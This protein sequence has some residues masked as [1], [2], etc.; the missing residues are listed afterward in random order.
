MDTG[1]IELGRYGLWCGQF[2]GRDTEAA[3]VA[4]RE[5][6]ALGYGT[7]W[8][9]GGAGGEI[10]EIMGRLLDGTTTMVAA[11]GIVNVWA[12]TPAE[13]ATA[14]AALTAAHPGRFLCGLGISHSIM[15]ESLGQTYD[16]PLGRLAEYLD[17]LDRADPPQPPTERVLAAL[18]SKMLELAKERSAGAHPYLTTPEHTAFARSVLGPDKVLAPEQ[19]VV[20]TDSPTMARGI[21]RQALSIYLGLPNYTNNLRRYGFTDKDLAPPGSDRLV[22]AVVAWGEPGAVAER[23]ARHHEAGADHVCVQVLTEEPRRFPVEEWRILAPL[24]V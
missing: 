20:L 17:E 4:A 5:A 10:F 6:E 13:V 14:H 23:V 18:G 8:V 9:P 1:V 15:V 2:R 12:H 16:R 11:T 22:D 7:L 24:L 3:A 21:A 19:K